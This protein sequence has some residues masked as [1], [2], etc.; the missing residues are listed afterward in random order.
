MAD[1]VEEEILSERTNK[2]RRN[3]LV[4]SII[5][6]LL[7]GMNGVN[8]KDL[9]LFGVKLISEDSDIQSNTNTAIAIAIMITVYF[10]AGFILSV[11]R[12][13]HVRNSEYQNTDGFWRS[14]WFYVKNTIPHYDAK[15]IK[16]RSFKIMADWDKKINESKLSFTTS[17]IDYQRD[18]DS[19]GKCIK[20]F[21]KSLSRMKRAEKSISVKGFFWT[22]EIGV[23]F[24]ILAITISTAWD[25][26]PRIL[27]LLDQIAN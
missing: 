2:I 20:T 11:R 14:S 3:L 6:I 8:F 16:N 5:T 10:A 26:I 24:F 1:K 21:S 15:I 23:P 19:H 9:S 22:Y 17:S 7:T 4:S 25:D 12:D 27:W 13:L 18:L